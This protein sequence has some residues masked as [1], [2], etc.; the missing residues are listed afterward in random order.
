MEWPGKEAMEPAAADSR[1]GLAAVA[2]AALLLWLWVT[3]P[4][5]LGEHTLYFRDVFTTHVPLKAF[6]ASALRQGSIPVVNPSWALGQPFRGNPNALPFYP[7]NLLYAFLPFWSAFNLHFALHW[8]LAGLSMAALAR[9]LDQGRAA[10]LVAGLTYA[11]SGWILSCLTF[12]NLLAVSAW[13]PLVLFGAVRGGRRGVAVG[14][15]A[16]GM[17]LLGGEPVTAA[18]GLVPLLVSAGQR[19]GARRGAAIV[20]AIGATGLLVALPQIVATARVLGFASRTALGGAAG[21]GRFHSEAARLLEL[22]IPFP[23]GF[24][25]ETGKGGYWAWSEPHGLPYVLTLHI[26]IVAL[27]L[28]LRGVRRARS[29]AFLAFGGLALAW[30]G[31]LSGDA[32]SLLTRGLVRYPEKLLFWYA[33]AV[34][35]LAGWG[36]ERTVAAR[37]WRSALAGA[38]LALAAAAAVFAAGPRLTA[39]LAAG[40]VPPNRVTEAP[41]LRVGN[42]IVALLLSAALLALAAV[43]AR[44]R[45]AA[46]LAAAQLVALLPLARLVAAAPVESFAPSSW[47]RLLRPGTQIVTSNLG[48]P[49]GGIEEWYELPDDSYLTLVRLGTYDLEPASGVPAGLRYPLARDLD[50]MYSPFSALVQRSLPRLDWDRRANWFR[51]L[52]V[53]AAVLDEA[54]GTANLRLADAR[55]RLGGTSRLF[56]VRDPAPAAYWP[57]S[58]KA[59]ASPAAA[60]REVSL[61]PDPVAQVVADRALRHIPGAVVRLIRETADSIEVEVTGRGGLLVLRRAYQPFYRARTGTARLRTLPANLVL[62]GVEVPSGAHRVRIETIAWP[63]D[64]AAGLALGALATAIAFAWRR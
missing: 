19:H 52:G 10:A 37:T 18:L 47:V 31:G 21:P 25:W 1:R 43:A 14:G 4:L 11:G 60:L 46:G 41:P 3:L 29:W 54:P 30:A 63:E 7:G 27:W 16:C 62:L 33:L 49:L 17:A 28:A 58:V 34:P 45:S 57:R 22:I 38:G 32:F 5:A 44:R 48:A 13:W 8:L 40:R 35:L 42:W 26:G 53:Q 59:V 39:W 50:G 9:A 20:L 56:L 61:A 12:Y 2:A 64:L 24:P 23:F 51:A 36:L 6:G 55:E 15:I